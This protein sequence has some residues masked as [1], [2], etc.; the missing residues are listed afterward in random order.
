MRLLS[1]T[2]QTPA[3]RVP[4]R[5]SE[6]LPA[7]LPATLQSEQFAAP[8]EFEGLELHPQ[9]QLRIDRVPSFGR[10]VALDL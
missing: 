10:S 4:P 5:V 9:A 8:A 6:D 1:V 3:P 2:L 7:A